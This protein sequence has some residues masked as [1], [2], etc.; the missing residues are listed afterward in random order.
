MTITIIIIIIIIIVANRRKHRYR[1][2]SVCLLVSLTINIYISPF[3][4]G[5]VKFFDIVH[6]DHWANDD[7]FAKRTLVEDGEPFS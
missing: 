6:H 3:L 2:A 7:G 4:G 1:N 5:A